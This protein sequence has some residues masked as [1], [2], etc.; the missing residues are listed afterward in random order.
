MN[1]NVSSS[2]GSDSGTEQ[3]PQHPVI[4]H[5]RL[6]GRG[7]VILIWGRYKY[8]EIGLLGIPHLIIFPS[9]QT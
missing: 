5:E 6:E 7:S 3:D 9:L 8:K 4:R 1:K 2:G